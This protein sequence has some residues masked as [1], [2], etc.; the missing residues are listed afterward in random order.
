MGLDSPVIKEGRTGYAYTSDFS[1]PG[2]EETV[3]AAVELAEIATVDEHRRLPDPLPIPDDYLR[4]YDPELEKIPTESKIDFAKI[5][6]KAALDY[7]ECV[8]MTNRSV[9][10]MKLPMSIWQIQRDSQD[11]TAALWQAVF[12]SVWHEIITE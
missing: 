4:I 11:H 6:E 8:V 12:C 10:L 7:D 9:S 5:V 1:K 2:I 3:V